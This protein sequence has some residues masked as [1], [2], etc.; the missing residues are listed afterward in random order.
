MSTK[1]TLRQ[2]KITKWRKSLYLDFYPAIRIPETMKL[3]RREFLGIY[4]HEKPKTEVEKEYNKE[5]LTKAEAI[6]SQRIQQVVND[7]FG[8]LDKGRMKG[9]FI[10]YFEKQA[11]KK[12]SKWMIVYNHFSKFTQGSCTFGDITVDLCNKFREHLLNSVQLKHTKY[13]ISQNTASSYFSTFQALLK[14]A[15]KDR[16]IKENVNE[17][18]DRIDKVDTKREY[19]TLDEVKILVNTP[20]DIDVLKSASLFSILTGLR[21]SDILKLDW[22]EIVPASDGGYCI[23]FQTLKT[24]TEDTLPISDEALGLCGER[25]EGKVFKGLERGMTYQPLKIWIARAGI[26]RKIT[27]HCFR[28]T[29]ATLQIALGT[30]IYTVSKML[31]H[32]NI[33]TTEIYAK[34]VNEKKKES[35]NKI[36]LK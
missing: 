19:L 16:L 35:A 1:V 36:S 7:E 29:F 13:K 15:Y 12:N 20:C 21:I 26:H 11:S 17:F 25:S 10:A 18:L 23:R 3:T 28:H 14:L 6:R 32:K 33:S 30:D 34:L 2:K 5:M 31:T 24:K 4:I 8:F 9:D 27:F 22:R